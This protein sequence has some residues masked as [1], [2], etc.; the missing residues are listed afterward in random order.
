M[1]R[2]KKKSR[3]LTDEDVLK[4]LFPKQVRDEA[5]KTALESRKKGS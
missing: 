5:K 3:E 1:P 2:R 4:K